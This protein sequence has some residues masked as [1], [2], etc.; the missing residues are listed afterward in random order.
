MLQHPSA[1]HAFN[2]FYNDK[3]ICRYVCCNTQVHYMT[4]IFFTMTTKFVGMCVAK[5]KHF[6]DGG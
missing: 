4:L 1:L 6:F 3:E 5:P 2:I